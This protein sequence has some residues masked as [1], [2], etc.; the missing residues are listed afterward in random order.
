MKVV[1]L[2]LDEVIALQADQ[3]GRYGGRPGIRDL[4][5]L[6]SALGTS[7]ATFEG[8]FLH[9]GLHEMAAAYLFHIVRNYPFVDGNK[10]VGLMVMLAFLG[11]NSRRLDAAP[12]E[13]EDLVLGIASGRISKAEAAVFVQR[14]LR[15]RSAK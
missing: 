6:Q 12:R 7:A 4:G 15:S 8:R 9:E 11:L 2:T 14:H 5:L 13:V 10:R 1:F 3:I